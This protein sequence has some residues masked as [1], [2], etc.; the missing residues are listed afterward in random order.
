[1]L[2]VL[3]NVVC[4]RVYVVKDVTTAG[5]TK[6]RTV[7]WTVRVEEKMSDSTETST[8]LTIVLVMLLIRVTGAGV[9]K[10]V[11]VEVAVT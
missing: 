11:G 4:D 10:M 1:M 3:V 8:V 5:V 2:A 9:A 7:D 6:S